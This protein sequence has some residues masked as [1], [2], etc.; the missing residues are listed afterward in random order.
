MAGDLQEFLVRL[1]RVFVLCDFGS[2]SYHA[3]WM[4]RRLVS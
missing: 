4:F 1:G 2:R 3:L